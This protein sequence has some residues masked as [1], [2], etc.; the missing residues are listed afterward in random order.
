MSECRNCFHVTQL[1]GSPQVKSSAVF[2]HWAFYVFIL[3]C[4]VNKRNLA[5]FLIYFI[6]LKI[7]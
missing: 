6:I 4:A 3:I 7:L 1:P 5:A 2:L